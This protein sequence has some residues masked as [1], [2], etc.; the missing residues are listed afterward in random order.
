MFQVGPHVVEG[1]KK[2]PVVQLPEYFTNKEVEWF[3]AQ[4]WEPPWARK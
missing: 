3:S 1:E 4:K 2:I